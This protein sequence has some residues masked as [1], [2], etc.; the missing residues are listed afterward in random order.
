MRGD[1]DLGRIDRN[2][3]VAFRNSARADGSLRDGSIRGDG[4]VRADGSIRG[5]A[6]AGSWLD[7]NPDRAR[8]WSDWS[9]NVKNNDNWD[10]HHH[11]SHFNDNFWAFRSRRADRH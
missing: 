5:D 1:R 10:G 11:H 2:L 7:R 4:S 8:H 6:T 9:D 3:D